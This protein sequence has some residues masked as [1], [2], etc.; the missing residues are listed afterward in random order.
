[1]PPRG[2]SIMSQKN[3]GDETNRAESQLQML[4]PNNKLLDSHQL[5]ESINKSALDRLT[6]IPITLKRELL[7]PSSNILAALHLG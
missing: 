5:R 7:M 6:T 3:L 2:E 4:P 1:M